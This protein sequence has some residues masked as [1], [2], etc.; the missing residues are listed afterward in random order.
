MSMYYK[1]LKVLVVRFIDS[2]K[3]YRV[4]WRGFGSAVDSWVKEEDCN[5]VIKN[6]G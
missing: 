3:E 1:V 4:R 6:Y 5:S 2:R